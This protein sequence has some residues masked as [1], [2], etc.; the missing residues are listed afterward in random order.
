[1]ATMA[2]VARKE[3]LEARISSEHKMLFQQ[4]ATLSG[5]SLTDFVISTLN[6]AARELVEQETVLRLSARD[7]TVFVDALV[8]PPAPSKKLRAAAGR[9]WAREK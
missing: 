4:A 3:R 8:S 5:L 6:R 9:Y 7:C 1:M 2:T